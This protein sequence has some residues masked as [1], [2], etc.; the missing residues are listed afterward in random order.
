VAERRTRALS[1][2]GETVAVRV[3]T[4]GRARRLRVTVAPDGDVRLSA[5]RRSSETAID[6]FLDDLRP[7]LERTLAA[8]RARASMLGLAR[9]GSVPLAGRHVPL[10][11][12]RDGR[13]SARVADGELLVTGAA[14][15]ASAALERLLRRLAREEAHAL[16]DAWSPRLGVRPRAVRIGDQRSRWGSA[17]ARGTVSFSW[18]LVLAPPSV[19]EYVAVHELC[20]LREL[21]HSPAF[22]SLV[23][24]ALPGHRAE[25]D[26]L[27]AHGGELRAWSPA[28]ALG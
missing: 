23:A 25:R 11:W 24:S 13:P 3:R 12:I 10:T 15:D 26:W 17:S 20:H 19:F 22:W 6:R 16:C 4:Y 7:W 18:R 8:Q 21:N 28:A 14:G 9:P 27:R 2:G 1:V 5:P